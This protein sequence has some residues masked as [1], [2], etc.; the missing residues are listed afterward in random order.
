MSMILY[1][2]M[3]LSADDMGRTCVFLAGSI[4]MGAA[5]DWQ[6]E[7]A[8]LIDGHV[9]IVLNP[10]R[11]AWDASWTQDISN[12]VF[13]EQV[14]WEL[15][16]IDHADAVFFYFAPGTMSPISLM[17]LGYCL[18]RGW[19]NLIV[20]C[21]PGYWR[22]GNVQIMC[23]RADVSCIKVHDDLSSG[24]DALKEYFA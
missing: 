19:E 4:E 13:R 15:D 1:P 2:P 18:G 7:V 11:A 12:R 5:I 16:H 14:D 20:V 24:I 21:P 22:R 10:R 8:R 9:E 6:A 23:A 3:S 17:E